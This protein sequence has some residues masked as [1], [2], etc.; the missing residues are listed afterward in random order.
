[1]SSVLERENEV[2]PPKMKMKVE[3]T[4]KAEEDEPFMSDEVV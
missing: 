2:K 4:D 1:M 3:K